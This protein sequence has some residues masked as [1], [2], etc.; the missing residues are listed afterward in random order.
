MPWKLSGLE[1]LYPKRLSSKIT[2]ST[3]AMPKTLS[4]ADNIETVHPGRLR[5]NLERSYEKA[6]LHVSRS[7]IA[8]QPIVRGRMAASQRTV[9][10]ALGKRGL[11]HERFA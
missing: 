2:Y 10:D 3:R 9:N 6:V 11:G 1:N 7:L 5:Q 8:I 4:P